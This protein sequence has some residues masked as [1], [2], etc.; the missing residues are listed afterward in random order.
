[1]KYLELEK[2]V[3]L[4]TDGQAIGEADKLKAHEN[5]GLLHLAF[6]IVV[7]NQAGELLLQRRAAV[8]YHFARLWS[9]T[10]CGHPRPGEE[11]IAAAERRLEEEL[12]FSTPLQIMEKFTYKA[13]DE[14]SGLTEHE[15]AYIL[16][17]RFDGDPQLNPQEADEWRWVPVNQVRN[18][19]Q[20][21]PDTFTP[22]FS[23]F[24]SRNPIEQ[25]AIDSLLE[26]PAT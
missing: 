5:G 19:I 17:G 4:D 3:L 25:W 9:N 8:K 16:R 18:E 12:G 7:F 14:K 13:Q 6:C 26:P 1:M 10:C 24:L 15:M 22:W 2:V 11:V 20:A 23:L 21:R